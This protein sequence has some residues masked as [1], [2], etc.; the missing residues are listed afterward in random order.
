MFKNKIYDCITFFDENLLTN[1]RFE[2]LKDVVDFFIVVES[3]YDHKGD[4]KEIN[5]KLENSN[6]KNKVRHIV[7]ENNFPDLSNGWAIEAYQREKILSIIDDALP[8][9][10]IMY[11]DSDEIPNPLKL[12]NLILKKKYGI[13]LQKFFVYK[14]NIF[15]KYETPWQGT[16]ICK[17]QYLKSITFLR[18]KIRVEN[19][20]KSF[21]KLQ[22]EKSIQCIDD[23]GWHFNNLYKPEI[24]SKKLQNI[25]NIDSG[26]INVHTDIE[27]IK[28]KILKLEDV[29][30]RNHKYEK[31]KID[32]SYPEYIRNNLNLFK[33][34]TLE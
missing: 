32:Q 2:I 8:E 34:Y 1:T 19:L 24:I 33:D 15:N 14:L 4:K 16:R 5:F 9:D 6:F 18:K 29:F 28:E 11:S 27:M 25:K 31:I 10:Y 17:K 7:I 23:G 3:N 20:R 13:F 22:Y 26:L 12:K 30:Y 21:W